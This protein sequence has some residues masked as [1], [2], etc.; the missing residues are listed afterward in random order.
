LGDF[1]LSKV[2]WCVSAAVPSQAPASPTPEMLA[3]AKEDLALMAGFELAR[4]AAGDAKAIAMRDGL[5]AAAD[6]SGKT[7]IETGPLPRLGARRPMETQRFGFSYGAAQ[8]L[9]WRRG[10][11][12][13]PPPLGATRPDLFAMGLDLPILE[14]G[15]PVV[16][17]VSQSAVLIREA[18]MARGFVP[19]DGKP[20][21]PAV[22]MP[23]SQ[24]ENQAAEPESQPTT[25]ATTMPTTYP[26][27]APAAEDSLAVIPLPGEAAVLLVQRTEFIPAYQGDY[28]A[29]RV[30]LM[31]QIE[32]L[33]R[34]GFLRQWFAQANVVTR[35]G[36]KA[37]G[38]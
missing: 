13:G 11:Q 37:K 6:A 21:A 12:Q 23:T 10:G 9:D 5:A 31:R 25:M 36:Y 29:A 38:D 8:V 3:K 4:K 26:T 14:I 17:G 1:L 34:Q 35:T 20:I 7:V 18:F 22:P 33:E 19:A 27:S 32:M 2:I 30:N 24:P 15:T 28:E 16:P